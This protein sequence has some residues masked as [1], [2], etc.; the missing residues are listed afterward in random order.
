MG[1]SKAFSHL[2]K[3][4]TGIDVTQRVEVSYFCVFVTQGYGLVPALCVFRSVELTISHIISMM[5]SI[6]IVHEVIF[7]D[8]ALVGL[9]LAVLLN[10]S[11]ISLQG[12]LFVIV[13]TSMSGI[14]FVDFDPTE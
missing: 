3:Y 1:E 11:G 2:V 13:W 5:L 8:G 10:G 14:N 9:A 6:G 7:G 12:R 4:A